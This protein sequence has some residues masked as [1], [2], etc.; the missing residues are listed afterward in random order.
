MGRLAEM[1]PTEGSVARGAYTVV[2]ATVG[3]A[4]A[5]KREHTVLQ[6][7]LVH[8]VYMCLSAKS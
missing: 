3:R 1:V 2:S 4:T 7:M 6:R 8:D 5:G